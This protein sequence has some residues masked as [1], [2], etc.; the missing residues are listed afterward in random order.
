MENDLKLNKEQAAFY[1]DIDVKTAVGDKLYPEFEHKGITV[2]VHPYNTY[3]ADVIQLQDGVANL[4]HVLTV[5]DVPGT[6]GLSA[7]AVLSKVVA[8][9]KAQYK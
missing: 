5:Q 4:D 3:K 8:A 1:K 2:W 7:E 9:A 6:A